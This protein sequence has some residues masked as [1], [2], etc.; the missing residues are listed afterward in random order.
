MEIYDF[1][2]VVNLE[3]S[4]GLQIEVAIADYRDIETYP[5]LPD[6]AAA[7]SNAEHVDLA[8]AVFVMKTG[9]KFHRFQGSLEKNAFN[10]NLVGPRGA[11]SFENTLTVI[12]N[13][14]NKDLTGWLRANRN[15][16]CIV[17]FRPLGE[18]QW[19]FLGYEGL[20][21]EID[22]GQMDIPGEIAG[23]KMTMFTVRSI[24]HPPFY[25]DAIPFTEGV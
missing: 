8:D 24:F 2:G 17:A 16:P 15:R 12:R 22:E 7:T 25:I 9:K 18:S 14:V 5:A 3:E 10:S 1:E 13:A 19:V 11:K 4:A 6:L 23:E 21:A 20:W